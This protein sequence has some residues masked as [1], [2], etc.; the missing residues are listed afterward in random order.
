[1]ELIA[2]V[3][4]QQHNLTIEQKG[5]HTYLVTIDD[6]VYEVDCI[7]VMDNLFSLVHDQKSYEVHTHRTKSGKIETHFYEDSFEVELADPMKLLLDQAMG[8]GVRG[9]VAL[10]A[11]MPGLV[12]RILVKEGDEVEED[13]GLLVLVAMKMENELGSPKAGKIKK[14][15]VKEGENVESGA[16]LVEIE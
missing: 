16:K 11:A 8:A 7:E 1:M 10:E 4:K 14:I 15:L 2:N 9:P 12:Q 3:N 6:Q 13:Q 5:E